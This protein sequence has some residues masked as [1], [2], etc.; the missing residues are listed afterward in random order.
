MLF[1]AVLSLLLLTS[2][3]TLHAQ[4]DPAG[5]ERYLLPVY[6]FPSNPSRG[7]FG[8]IWVTQFSARN[9]SDLP[10]QFFQE[11]CAAFCECGGGTICV[12]SGTTPPRTQILQALRRDTPGF[13]PGVFVYA[14]R[15]GNAVLQLRVR[16]ISREQTSWGTELP[17]VREREFRDTPIYLLDIPVREGFRQ[18]LRVYGATSPSG[19]ADVRVRVYNGLSNSLLS[20]HAL[21]LA[22]A[23]GA[24]RL[25]PEGYRPA[26]PAYAEISSLRDVVASISG[27]DTVR[28][29]V[30]PLTIGLRFWAF[31]SV[32]NN[33]T[34]HVTLVTPQ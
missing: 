23:E 2:P 19:M 18:H 30:A 29:E 26:L 21:S 1:R 3:A 6:L 32:T 13:N 15:T 5:Y 25:P 17:V 34:Q 16:D 14:G 22:P 33:D 9:E 7:A 10:V 24:P 11:E 4:R 12:P 27:V 20:E 28:L 31:V 8:S